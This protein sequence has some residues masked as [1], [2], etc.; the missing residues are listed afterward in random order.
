MEDRGRR[1]DDREDRRIVLVDPPS[2]IL[3]GAAKLPGYQAAGRRQSAQY[4]F[5]SPLW[6][7]ASKAINASALSASQRM[8][9]PLIRSVVARHIDSVGPL[10]MSRP[11][12]RNS[13]YLIIG[14]RSV[15]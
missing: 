6:S 7:S 5:H 12:S 1:M 10:P 11:C 9:T 8:P 15:T 2:S 14:R 13:G 3:W 4:T